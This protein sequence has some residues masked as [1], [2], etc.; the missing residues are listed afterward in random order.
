MA[1]IK[2]KL[3]GNRT[4]QGM[5]SCTNSETKHHV[6]SPSP[7]TQPPRSPTARSHLAQDGTFKKE[8]THAASLPSSLCKTRD[9][10]RE[11]SG[12]ERNRT[13]TT[14]PWR[15]T[16]PAGVAAAVAREPAKDFSRSKFATPGSP[17]SPAPATQGL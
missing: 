15:G 11:R 14:P 9:F 16:A 5:P 7:K 12:R 3:T 6:P 1:P 10:S 2:Q 13:L 17:P 8:A 4:N